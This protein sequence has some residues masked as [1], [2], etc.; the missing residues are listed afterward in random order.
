[1]TNV[2]YDHGDDDFRDDDVHEASLPADHE[3]DDKNGHV[4]GDR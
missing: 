3:D 1:M 4:A 2:Y